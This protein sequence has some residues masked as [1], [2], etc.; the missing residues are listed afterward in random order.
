[1]RPLYRHSCIG[2]RRPKKFLLC[3]CASPI[4]AHPA[5]GMAFLHPVS[6][7]RPW[8]CRARPGLD[9]RQPENKQAE[10]RLQ[11]CAWLLD[12][13]SEEQ[14]LQ[15]ICAAVRTIGSG[16]SGAWPAREPYQ[17]MAV[18]FRPG[19]APAATSSSCAL[20]WIFLQEIRVC[21]ALGFFRDC[22]SRTSR[23]FKARRELSP[24]SE[25][26]HLVRIVN[27]ACIGN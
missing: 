2:G 19:S 7:R 8:R 18:G 6:K 15:R 23:L 21:V 9:Q 3:D 27:R 4:H 16:A 22:R 5:R 26:P 10:I 17:R 25:G 11:S 14:P 20:P 24:K 13:L 1:M 12:L